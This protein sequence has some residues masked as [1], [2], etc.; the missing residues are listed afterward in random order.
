MARLLHKDPRDLIKRFSP[1]N[2]ID[3][4]YHSQLA[5]EVRLITVDAGDIIIRKSRNAKQMHFLVSGTVEVRE[6]FENR[7]NIDHTQPECGRAL[8]AALAKRASVKAVDSCVVLVASAD[9][10]DQYLTWSQDYS[11]FYLDETDLLVDDNDLIDDDFQEDWDNVFVRSKLAANMSNRAIHQLLS[12]VEDV[13]VKAG[14]TVVRANTSGDYFY[15]IKYGNAEVKTAANGPFCGK[16]FD[17]GP[18]NYFGDEALVAET[19]RN[20]TVTMTTDGVLGRLDADAFN[21]LIKQ[22]LVSQLTEDVRAGATNVRILDVRFPIEYKQGHVKDSVNLP[23][24][25]LRQRLDDMKESFLY[26]I[27]PA[28]DRRA[29]LATYLMRQAGFDAYQL[30]G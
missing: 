22:H 14:Q 7:F 25:S 21:H 8:E 13:E 26:V 30:P 23:I 5:S 24:S 10:I 4:K 9:Q 19:I 20:A 15:I 6:S 29:E 11:I 2:Q 3:H 1:L 16:C 17:L 27:S 12:Q 28:N 18:G